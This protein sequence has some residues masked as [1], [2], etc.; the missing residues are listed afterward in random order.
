VENLLQAICQCTA[1]ASAAP[2][3]V[4]RGGSGDDVGGGRGKMLGD[5][6]GKARR[7]WRCM[8]KRVGWEVLRG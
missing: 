7:V 4:S 2:T 6:H 5:E 8:V 1:T 3:G